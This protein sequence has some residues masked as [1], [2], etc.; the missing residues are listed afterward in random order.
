MID[1]IAGAL[2]ITG[3]VLTLLGAIGL[4]R[5]P[6]VLTRMHAATKAATLGVILATGAA[7]LEVDTFAAVSLLL[8]VTGL[9]VL[10]A[11]LGASLLARAA[12]RDPGTPRTLPDR[13]DLAGVESEEESTDTSDR[14]GAASLLIGWLA[15]VWVALFASGTPGVAIGAIGI[16]VVVSF[17]LTDYRPRWPQGIF[18]PLAAVRFVAVFIR[19]VIA[20]NVDV[21][22]AVLSRRR[23]RPAVVFV[24]VR[25]TTRTEV[26]LL[27][28]VITFT[29]GT[30]A[31]ELRGG[32]LFVH[33]MDLDDEK[34][35]LDSLREI[36]ERIVDAF[37]TPDE[38]SATAA[39]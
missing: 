28:N 38:R 31:L 37:G 25:V 4:V 11:P 5:F 20:A 33:V 26:V 16:A 34:A 17:A 30:V 7:A 36:E 2:V 24:P 13:D 35:F 14:P 9:L 8:L 22:R 12:Y 19:M 18:R 3:A 32:G 27:M 15:I 10:S 6:D 23:L 39:G 21:A 1:I 29:P